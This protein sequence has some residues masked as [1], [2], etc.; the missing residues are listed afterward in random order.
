MTEG[1][2]P[3]CIAAHRR[4]AAPGEGPENFQ[5]FLLDVPIDRIRVHQG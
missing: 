5:H 3:L 4:F 2:I 1:E